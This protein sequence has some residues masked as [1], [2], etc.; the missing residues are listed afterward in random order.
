MRTVSIFLLCALTMGAFCGRAFAA[1]NSSNGWNGF[2]ADTSFPY[3]NAATENANTLA[4]SLNEHLQNIPIYIGRQS[5]APDT[6]ARID[7]KSALNYVRV[8]MNFQ[9]D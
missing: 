4:N 3:K 9:F 1:T 8:G 7:P 6:D 5:Y 2:Y